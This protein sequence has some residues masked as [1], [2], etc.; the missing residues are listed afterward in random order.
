MGKM[1]KTVA[2]TEKPDAAKAMTGKKHTVA[3]PKAATKHVSP[4]AAPAKSDRYYQGIGGRKTATATVRIFPKQ[5]HLTVN[6]K[7]YTKYFTQ[8]RH[9]LDVVAPLEAAQ[10]K[11]A[12]GVTA[13]VSGGGMNAQAEAVRHGL[14]RALVVLNADLKKTLRLHGFMTRDAR[15]VERKKYGLRKARRAPQWAKR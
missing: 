2:K 8:P 12:V 10:M 11:G 14:S 13:F 4:A 15:H 6:G 1:I 7:E 9:Q 5:S 3:K